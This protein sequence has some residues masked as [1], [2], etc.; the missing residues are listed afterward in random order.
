[1]DITIYPKKLTGT[2]AAIPS[3]SQ[4][5]RLLICAA[6][7]R[8]RTTLLCPE[9]NRDI[10]A[11]AGCLQALG[12]RIVR[13]SLGFEVEPIET[14]CKNPV[15]NCH[16]SGSTLRFLLPVAGALGCGAVFQLEGRLPKRPLSP[17]WEELERM[18]CH[19]SRPT[20]DTVRCEG[21]LHPGDFTIDGG[22][23]SQFITGLLLAAAILPGKSRVIPTGKLESRPYIQMTLDALE[24]FGVRSRDLT[25]EGGLLR[26]PGTLAVEGDWSNAAFFLAAQALGS[27]LEVTNLSPASAQGDRAAAEL[28]P[29]L[30]DFSTISAADIPDLVPILSIVAACNKGA[31]FTDIRRLRLKESDRV[32]SVIAMVEA[33]GGRAE[34]DENS[35]TVYGTGLTGGTVDS[36]GDHRIAMSAAVGATVCTE[37]VTIL[38]AESV[39]KSYPQFWEEYRRL[40]GNYEQ[41]LR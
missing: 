26:S 22:V 28:I 8:G 20:A 38:G 31:V 14:P 16:D 39:G 40:G 6:L 24:A 12:A 4:A 41:Y 33:L 3:K 13:T 5:H 2:V 36:V 35:L 9:T 25:L 37:R 19:L 1:M 10:E 23:S 30:S 7:G 17:L 15:L 29:Q 34:A 21:Q 32:A 27:R 18:G 11:T